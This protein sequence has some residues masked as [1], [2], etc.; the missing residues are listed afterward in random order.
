MK[1]KQS[2]LQEVNRQ[3]VDIELLNVRVSAPFTEHR[4]EKAKHGAG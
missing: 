4:G 3:E 2:R 1:T